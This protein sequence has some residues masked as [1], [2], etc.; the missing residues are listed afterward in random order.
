MNLIYKI[1]EYFNKNKRLVWLLIAI[2]ILICFILCFRP[3]N[4]NSNYYDE[5]KITELENA[6]WAAMENNLSP[7][8][9]S[10]CAQAIVNEEFKLALKDTEQEFKDGMYMV[11]MKNANDSEKHKC[12]CLKKKLKYDF[13]KNF[14]NFV[15]CAS[16]MS[17]NSGDYQIALITLMSLQVVAF[18]QCD[19][20]DVYARIVQ[21]NFQK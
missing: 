18:T 17:Q 5:S 14:K 1:I 8:I 15:L 4:A 10:L 13:N 21:A 6:T 3:V 11:C 19:L 2:F 12:K 20:E 7:N 16:V 9:M